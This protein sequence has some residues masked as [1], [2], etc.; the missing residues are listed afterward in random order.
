MLVSN[1]FIQIRPSATEPLV[2]VNSGHF[3]KE[4]GKNSHFDRI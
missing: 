1:Q 2:P 3:V 4:L